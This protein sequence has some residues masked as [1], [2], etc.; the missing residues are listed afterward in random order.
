MMYLGTIILKGGFDAANL[1]DY[2]TG[3]MDMS[4]CNI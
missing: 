2:S 1:D 3:N 4:L